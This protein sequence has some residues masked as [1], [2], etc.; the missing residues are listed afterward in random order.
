MDKDDNVTTLNTDKTV[1]IAYTG[2]FTCANSLYIFA[3]NT[4]GKADLKTKG[5]RIH[6]L[7]VYDDDNAVRNFIPARHKETGEIGMY[8]GVEL[9]FYKNAGTGKFIAGKVKGN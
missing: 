2:T 7:V 3:C 6:S 5:V 9:K 1:T 4:G 8:D